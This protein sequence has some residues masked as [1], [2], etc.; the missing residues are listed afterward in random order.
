MSVA[1]QLEVDF[2]KA[3]LQ[4]YDNAKKIG[5]NAS[6]FRNMVA[7]QGG[8]NVAKKF[9]KNNTPSDGFTSLWELGRLD[10]TV[11]ALVLSPEYANLFSVEEKQ[12]VRER[13]QEYGFELTDKPITKKKEQVKTWIFQGNPKVFDIDNYVKNNKYIWWSLR[14]E[15]FESQINIDD[16]VFLWRSDGGNRGTG[17][18]LAKTRVVEL[19]A[20]HTESEETQNY[21]YTD[22]WDNDYLAV[23]LEV[24]EVRLE[25]GFV[26]RISILEHETLKELLILRLRQQTNYLLAEEH[27]EELHNLWNKQS[28]KFD[29]F[30]TQV[31]MDID[32]EIADETGEPLQKDGKITEYYGKR[33][34]RNPQN[35]ARALELHGFDCYVCGFNF[36]KVY[37]DR[38]KDFIEVHH[39]NPLGTVKQEV[40]INPET[41]LLPVCSNCH[42]MIHRSKD[43]VLSIDELKKLLIKEY[44]PS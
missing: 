16:V 22:D 19:P 34:E 27:A 4:I 28:S 1:N 33:Y 13:L 17:G 2:H 40:A 20:N 35:R 8:L 15:H 41:D 23:K 39:V 21:W 11:E 5:Y 6:R 24:Q 30:I 14:Q 43:D 3:M 18:I 44:Q 25:N 42:R 38:G 26:N 7:N 32:S 10:L 12:I 36:E 37:G 29:L 9:I 31:G